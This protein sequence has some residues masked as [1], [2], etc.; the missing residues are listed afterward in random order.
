MGL[1]EKYQLL[2]MLQDGETRS[3]LAEEIATRRSV[4]VHQIF[5]ELRPPNEP[6]M[7][8]LVFAFLRS[9]PPEETRH[10]LDMGRDDYRVC[11]VTADEPRCLELRMWLQNSAPAEAADRQVSSLPT[12]R[13]AP[14]APALSGSPL[15]RTESFGRLG[16]TAPHRTVA[17]PS[18]VPPSPPARLQG[19]DQATEVTQAF[20]TMR[21]AAGPGKAPKV[22]P[23]IPPAGAPVMENAPSSNFPLRPHRAPAAPAAGLQEPGEF[24]KLFYAKNV[25]K[26][27]TGTPEVPVA[28][29]PAIEK[30]PTANFPLEPH[31]P[32]PAPA[33]GLQ[34]PGEFTKL[35]YAKDVL[36][37]GAEAPNMPVAGAPAIENVPASEFWP[38]PSEPPAEPTSGSQP[39]GEF[40]QMFLA[41][42]LHAKVA[43]EPPPQVWETAAPVLN[44]QATPPPSPDSL[45]F[46]PLFQAI[47]EQPGAPPPPASEPRVSAI[48][49]SSAKSAGPGEFTQMFARGDARFGEPA[50]AHSPQGFAGHE[51]IPSPGRE[52]LTQGLRAGKPQGQPAPET[53]VRQN[54]SEPGEITRLLSQQG[55]AGTPPEVRPAPAPFPGSKAPSPEAPT[56]RFSRFPA[57]E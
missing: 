36:K 8:S 26:A 1:L 6:D 41:K 53:P 44:P 35:F 18:E 29:A 16:R 34:E 5:N 37:A 9:A 33:A 47:N 22:T 43:A 24:T 15:G 17:R 42:D 19:D 32:Q 51:P 11:I 52:E 23:D 49:G 45:G 39:P 57:L 56:E 13:N 40:T 14:A 3:Y 46:G 28:G 10:F 4:Y 31:K 7:P 48:P 54:P 55:K 21:P 30:P 38:E 20:F 50:R 12:P 2:Q 27:G 25:L